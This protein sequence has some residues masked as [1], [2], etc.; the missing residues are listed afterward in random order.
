[1]C[2]LGSLWLFDPLQEGREEKK[3]GETRRKKTQE[4]CFFFYYGCVPSRGSRR[5]PKRNTLFLCAIIFVL[6]AKTQTDSFLSLVSLPLLQRP[7][8]SFLPSQSF[9][10]LT[11]LPVYLTCLF[12]CLLSSSFCYR[13]FFFSL[14]LSHLFVSTSTHAERFFIGSLSHVCLTH[15]DGEK[16]KADEKRRKKKNH[17]L[18]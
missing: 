16:R 5:R 17:V 18:N 2:G 7:F 13:F 15:I 8:F 14:Y 11:F 1:M 6:S 9:L 12:V 4:R 10:V 3:E